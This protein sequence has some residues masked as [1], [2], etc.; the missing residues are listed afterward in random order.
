MFWSRSKW[1][2]TSKMHGS[3]MCSRFLDLARTRSKLK[4]KFDKAH[5]KL[6]KKVVKNSIEKIEL[7]LMEKMRVFKKSHKKADTSDNRYKHTKRKV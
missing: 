5:R 6:Q 2:F 1:F 4:R 7:K 3:S